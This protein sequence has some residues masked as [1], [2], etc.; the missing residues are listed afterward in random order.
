[1]TIIDSHAHLESRMFDIPTMIHEMDRAGVDKV[2]LIPPM[3]D[4]LPETPD[5]L[6]AFLR[7]LMNSRFHPCAHWLS[8][9][10]MTP[11]GDVK[12]RGQIYRI[13]DRP[14]NAMVADAL[15]QHPERFLGW[16]FL[17]PKV[18]DDPVEELEKWREVP[19]FIGVKLHPHW[20]GYVI[21]D[22]FPIAELC[23]T[24]NLPILIHL[25]FGKRG[26]WQLLT[27]RYPRLRMI[28]AHAGMPHFGRMWPDIA[29]NRNLRVDLSSPYLD[30]KL[31][32]RAVRAIGP[33]RSLF[34]TDAPY[35]FHQPG[36]TPDSHGP[37]DYFHIKGWVER[38]PCRAGEIDRILGGNVEEFLA[39]AR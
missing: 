11:S 17:N 12:L 20:H 34:G 28:F 30:E 3:N 13:Y 27:S 4:P 9:R 33:E 8:N 5:V 6:L 25:G 26:R 21:E 16:I 7:K 19:G 39:E 32:R 36:S 37:Y 18:M 31:V 38:L 29:E 22:V 1:M 14:D 2:A 35:G 24:L 23:Q 15:K 10:F